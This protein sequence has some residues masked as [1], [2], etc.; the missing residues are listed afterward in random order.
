MAVADVL[1]AVDRHTQSRQCGIL[2]E[3]VVNVLE[4]NLDLDGR[5]R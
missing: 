5:G 4:L 1:A 2:G 3:K